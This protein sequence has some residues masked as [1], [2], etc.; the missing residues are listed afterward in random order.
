MSSSR[1]LVVVRHAKA[2]AAPP[3]G[4]DHARDL[5]PRGRRDA[6][7]LGSW[8]RT[9]GVQLDLVLCSTAVRAARTWQLAAEQLLVAPPVED[10]ADL[11]LAQPGRLLQ[12]VREVDPDVRRLAVVGH[13]PT[14]SM[15]TTA[16]ADDSSDPDAVELLGEGFATSGVALLEVDVP[17]DALAPMGARLTAFAV[18]R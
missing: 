13:E 4:D 5:S 9:H 2:E 10:R 1:T 7:A 15:L 8:L 6:A 3:G 18:P 17:W 12:A 11:Y 14:Q 16:L